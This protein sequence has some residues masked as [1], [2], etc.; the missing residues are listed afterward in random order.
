[1]KAA[2]LQAPLRETIFIRAPPGYQSH[3]TD[4]EEEILELDNALYGLKQSG[5]CFWEAMRQ[6]LVS[7][8]FT[9]LLGDPCFFRKVLPNGQVILACTYV[10]DITYGVSDQATADGFLS[11]LR[12]RFVIDEGEG[13]PIDF[14]L[15]MAVHQDIDKGTIRLNMEMA[16]TKLCMGVLT[17]EELAKAV[18]EPTPMLVTPLLKATERTVPKETF[19]YLSVVGSLMHIANCIR[20]DISFAV[21]ILARH[22]SCPGPSHV[23]AAKRVLQYLYSTRALGITYTKPISETSN[24]VMY[25]GASHPLDTG[26]NRLQVFA[27]SD[28]AADQSRRSTMGSVLMMNGGPVS[29]ASVL[30]KTVAMSTCEAEVNAAVAAAKDALHLKQLLVDSGHFDP[31]TPLQIGEDNAACM[32]QAES[33]LRHVR[34]AKHYEIRLRLLQELVV[35]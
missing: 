4:G 22:A 31:D 32:A 27:D 28:Y 25:E 20:C 3:T 33:G 29:W 35:D 16:I 6:H 1:V 24:P 26:H 10:D 7:N 17:K 21:G 19:D 11:L 14:L 12:S 23:R 8:G 2:F 5:A 34:N 13:A 15:G 18:L 9:S 30:G